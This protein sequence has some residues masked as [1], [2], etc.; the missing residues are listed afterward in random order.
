MGWVCD[1]LK[2]FLW[3]VFDELYVYIKFID[4]FVGKFWTFVFCSF[5]VQMLWTCADSFGQTLGEW[6]H[7]LLCNN[8]GFLYEKF[9]PVS[10]AYL[11]LGV[12]YIPS[13]STLVFQIVP[14]NEVVGSSWIG[15]RFAVVGRLCCFRGLRTSDSGVSWMFALSKQFRLLLQRGWIFSKQFLV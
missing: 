1:C 3:A 11:Q 12:A 6:P 5:T 15:F 14:Q 10:H 2:L 4:N 9:P 8:F 13:Y 7:S